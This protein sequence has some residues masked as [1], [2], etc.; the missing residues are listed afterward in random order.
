MFDNHSLTIL[1]NED[2]Q[3]HSEMTKEMNNKL[4]RRFSS[5]EDTIQVNHIEH[6]RE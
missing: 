3:W 5:T 1:R 6:I 4:A 2:N